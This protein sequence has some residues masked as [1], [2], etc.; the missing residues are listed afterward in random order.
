[1]NCVG[2]IYCITCLPNGK[3]YIGQTTNTIMRRWHQH[4]RNA[5]SYRCKYH[6]HHA[7]R[8][9]G[10]DRFLV[11]EV[12]SFVAPS[13]EVLTSKLNYVEQRL[14]KNL[15]LENSEKGYNLTM[16]G[17]TVINR[18]RH[19]SEEHRRKLSESKRGEKNPMYGKSLSDDHKKKL[20]KS[21]RAN[22]RHLTEEQ[23]R[24]LAEVNAGKS[25]PAWNK[26]V[27]MSEEQKKK[28]SKKL[29]GVPAPWNRRPCSAEKAKKISEKLKGNIPWN[30]GLKLKTA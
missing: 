22:H 25:H 19:L 11:E 12:I 27:P 13:V 24:H 2:H 26:G 1:M 7:I 9:Y 4:V 23:K 6:L 16:G 20:S 8:K 15:D 18:G 14:I 29:K 5:M 17:D 10:A 30:K 3:M 21:L 28:L